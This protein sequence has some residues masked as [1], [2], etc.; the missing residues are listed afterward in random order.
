MRIVPIADGADLYEFAIDL[1]G[2]IVDVSVVRGNCNRPPL[3]IDL[4]EVPENV[5]MKL[6]D[7]LDNDSIYH[8]RTHGP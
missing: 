2:E 6:S 5:R 4:W 1:A 3:T 7:E 8:Y